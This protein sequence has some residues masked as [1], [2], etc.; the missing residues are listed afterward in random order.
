M[1][2]ARSVH[3]IREAIA[4]YTRFVRTEQEKLTKIDTDL[5]AVRSDLRTLR[6]RIGDPDKLAP[7]TAAVLPAG[8]IAQNDTNSDKAS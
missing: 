7:G 2:L 5:T 4:P 8:T 1:R 3:R 6:H